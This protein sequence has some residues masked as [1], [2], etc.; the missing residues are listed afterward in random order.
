MRTVGRVSAVGMELGGAIIVCLLAGW[1][2]DG[3]LGTGPW[4]TVVGVLIGSVAGFRAVY[5][6]AKV[7]QKQAEREAAEERKQDEED[8]AR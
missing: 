7:M 4:L 3:K 6:A 8:D 5:R 1:W 2:L